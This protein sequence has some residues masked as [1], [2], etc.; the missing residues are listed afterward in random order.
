MYSSKQPNLGFSGSHWSFRKKQIKST[1]TAQNTFHAPI[2]I[3]YLSYSFQRWA[4]LPFPSQN[5]RDG[6][7]L[8]CV[9]LAI[10]PEVRP[11]GL[12]TDRWGELTLWVGV[13]A[14]CCLTQGRGQASGICLH[15]YTWRS[16]AVPFS[17]SF[18]ASP[19]TGDQAPEPC[20]LTQECVTSER[21]FH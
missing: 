20:A 6:T 19:R 5:Q 7:L 9:N 16:S 11:A 8:T 14:Q 2:C 1:W 21:S 4:L 12:G 10:M 13:G 17:S 15:L 3:C 18:P